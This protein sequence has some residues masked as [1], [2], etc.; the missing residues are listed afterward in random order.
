MKSAAIFLVCLVASLVAATPSIAGPGTNFFDVRVFGASGDGK[1]LDTAAIQAALDACDKAGGGI[2]RFTAGTY[3][4]KPIWLYSKTTLQLE[5]GAMLKAT[6]ERN[7]FA[8]NMPGGFTAFINGPGLAD[9]TISGPGTIDGSGGKWWVPAEEARQKKSGYTLPRPNLIM[10]TGCK[11]VRLENLTLQNSPKFHFVPT[12]CEGVV[13]SNVTIIAPP[14]SPNTDAIDPSSCKNVLITRCRIDVG[15]DNVAIKSSHKVAGREFAN[16]DIT[17]SDCVFLHGHGLSIGS[18]TGGGVNN[19]L[20]R[21]CTF[22]GT[23]SGIRIKS[24]RDRGGRVENVVYRDLVMTNV[25]IPINITCYYPKVPPTDSARPVTANTPVFR[26]IQ[27]SNLV[28]VSQRSAGLIVGLPESCVSNVVLE[29]VTLA[30]ET[31]LLIRNAKAIR[32]KNV[33]VTVQEGGPFTLENAQV[34]GLEN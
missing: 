28:S 6:D 16:E 2:V 8:A 3:L 32:L 18:E 5:A 7:D 20:V 1:T 24:A 21:N 26:D 29:N 25:E 22:N 33:K 27:I 12:E 13:V 11:N 4:S 31:G 17:V 9:V 30:S 10:L 23:T 15:D 19:L 34:K 14:R